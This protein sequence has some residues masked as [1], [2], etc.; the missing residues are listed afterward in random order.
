MSSENEVEAKM[1]LF[2]SNKNNRPLCKKNRRTQIN[3]Q[4]EADLDP[5]GHLRGKENLQQN[6]IILFKKISSSKK[7]LGWGN[8]VNTPLDPAGV[9][10]TTAYAALMLL[11]NHHC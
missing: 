9:F 7:I 11:L 10:S 2:Y 8:V 3:D 6:A 1:C 4:S 5:V